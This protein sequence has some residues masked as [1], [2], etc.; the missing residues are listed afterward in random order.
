[1]TI[2]HFSDTHLGF[3]AYGRTG[4]LGMN[5]R[6]VD[7]MDTFRACLDAIAEREPDIVV[8]SGDLF[9]KVRPS[10]ATIHATF[11]ALSAFQTKRKGAPFILIGGNHDTPRLSESGNILNLFLEIPGVFLRTG[12]AE[13]IDFADLDLEVLCVPSHSIL[14]R[15]GRDWS[16]KLN[17]KHSILTLHGMACQAVEEASQFQIEDT[18]PDKWSY[19]ALGDYHIFAKYGKN[20]CYPGSTDFTSSNIW[21]EAGA[22]KGWVWFDTETRKLE[23]VELATRAV[24]DLPAINA[25]DMSPEELSEAMLGAAVWPEG[26]MPIVRQRI[27]D[28]H[29]DVRARLDPTVKRELN[30]KCLTYQPRFLLSEST[31]YSTGNGKVERTTMEGHWDEHVADADLPGGVDRIALRQLGNSL[32]LEVAEVALDP[33]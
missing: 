18:M 25:L 20:I 26:L 33:A 22:P 29:R 21:E 32:L 4:P 8:H 9:D 11:R 19:V 30:D 23:F 17:R 7:V 3:R 28:V 16:P 10:N 24:L 27:V 2:A 6:E 15:A 31:Q 1:M 12:A 5:Q 13:S 14:S